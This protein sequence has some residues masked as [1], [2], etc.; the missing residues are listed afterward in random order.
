MKKLIA[1]FASLVLTVHLVGCTSNS[2]KEDSTGD[3]AIADSTGDAGVDSG[4]DYG[5]DSELDS[6]DSSGGV[7][8]DNGSEGFLDEQLPEEALGEASPADQ[9]T[10]PDQAVIDTPVQ[11]F[12]AETAPPMDEATAPSTDEN[13]F[14]T[15]MAA[16]DTGMSAPPVIEPPSEPEPAPVAAAPEPEEKPKVSLKKV[17]TTPFKRSGVLLNAVYVARPTDSFASISKRIYGDE[18][19]S[20]ELKKVNPYFSKPR[21][22]DKVYYN[23][24]VRPT[25]DSRVMNYYEDAGMVPDV[26]VTKEGD[27]IRSVAPDLLGYDNAWKEIW[28]TNAVESKGALPAGTELRYWR[29]APVAITPPPPPPEVAPPPPE[30][31]PPPPEMAAA[32][33]PPEMALPPPEMAPPPPPDMAMNQPPPDLPP[34][35]PAEAV[36]PPPPPPMKKAFK[37]DENIGGLDNDMMMSLGFAAIVLVGGAAIMIVRKRRSQRDMTSAFNDTQV[38]T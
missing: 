34:P 12:A 19:R 23:S 35:P 8:A 25:D 38:G 11:D 31:T 4:L 7:A 16:V 10:A 30:M 37:K 24:P 14:D 29:Q 28:V 3:D 21:P 36:N 1:L 13:P 20:K 9:G 17:V 6:F 32:P 15:S 26:Y 27:N 5:T 33:P 2:S 18:G 22:G